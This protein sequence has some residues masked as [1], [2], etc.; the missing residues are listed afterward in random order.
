MSAASMTPASHGRDWVAIRQRYEPLLEGV[1]TREEFALVLQM[2]VGELEASHSEVSPSPSGV[3][4]P[5]TPHLGFTIDYSHSG[6]GLKV[7]QVPD[8]APGSYP[9]TRIRPG[10][11][12]LKINGEPVR[13]AQSLWQLI[14]DKG[15]RTFE[16]LVNSKPIEEGARVVKYKPLSGGEWSELQY[17]NR[18]ERARRLVEERSGGKIGYVHIAGMGG[19]NQTRFEREFY[20]YAQ[21]KQA[22]IIDVRFNGGGNIADTLVDWL[23]RKPYAFYVPRDG[24]P[25]V[26]PP[27]ALDMPMVVLMNERSLSNG[28]MFPYAMRARKLATLIGWETPGYVIWTWG[29]GLVDGT[30]ARMP[31]QGAYR[32]DGSNMENNGEKPDIAVWLSPEDWLADRD[33]QLDKALE[34][35]GRSVER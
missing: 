3:R 29:L 2:M 4:S 26:G 22:M 31:Q 28:E 11:Y 18:I 9:E 24:L 27:N 10:E 17:R 8:G 7:A 30:G 1:E 19:G 25:A 35:L 14:N 33:P 16:F 5:N 34:M 13:P 21:D 20:E 23:E 15:D 6:P 12:V 32:I